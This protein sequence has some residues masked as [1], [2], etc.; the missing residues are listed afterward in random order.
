MIEVVFQFIFLAPY[1]KYIFVSTE[2]MICTPYFLT[3]Q[4]SS[5]RE[6]VEGKMSM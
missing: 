2:E 6:G 4:L 1:C 5:L 3:L